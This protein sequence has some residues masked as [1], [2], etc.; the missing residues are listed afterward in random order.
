MGSTYYQAAYGGPN[1][2]FSGIASLGDSIGGAIDE[3][4]D[5]KRIRDAWERSGGDYNRMVQEL[6][7]AGNAKGA[8]AAAV[9]ANKMTDG[10]MTP[11]QRED[12]RLKELSLGLKPPA[13]VQ[14]GDQTMQWSDG[15]WKPLGQPKTNTQDVK[16]QRDLA[17]QMKGKENLSGVLA[18]LTDTI[19]ELDESG[20]MT[21]P[22][23]GLVSNL[24]AYVGATDYGQNVGTAL[25]SENQSKRKQMQNMRTVV[26][27]LVRIAS[28][29]SARA[30]DS[31]YELQTYLNSIADPKADKYSNLVAIDVLDQTFGLG[32]LLDRKL[33]QDVL[34]KVRAGSA[35]AIK[36]RPIQTDFEQENPALPVPTQSFGAPEIAPATMPGGLPVQNQPMTGPQGAPM[37]R[38]LAP[39]MVVGG[40]RFRGGNPND[41]NAWEQ[42]Q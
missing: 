11:Y 24:G 32:G 37:D 39:G 19:N 20:G 35:Q 26:S 40:F 14:A 30:F 9:I 12:L 16:A 2:D 4:Q 33:P 7:A 28:G 10:G 8:L 15:D 38:P 41:P 22:D 18:R 36:D 21:N 34:L 42:A 6:Y 23:N 13:T 29:M 25:G 3:R 5:T 1:L 31:N 27:N 17:T